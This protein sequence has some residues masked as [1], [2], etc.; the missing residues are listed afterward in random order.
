MTE[1]ARTCNLSGY[2][3]ISPPPVGPFLTLVAPQPDTKHSSLSIADEMLK[4][5]KK[6]VCEFEYNSSNP[7]LKV[8]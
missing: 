6:I 1:T 3:N 4:K 8:H 7:K 5:V 2:P